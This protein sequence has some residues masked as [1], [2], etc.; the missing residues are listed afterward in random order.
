MQGSGL[1][2][3]G[4]DYGTTVNETSGCVTERL[5]A[6]REGLPSMSYLIKTIW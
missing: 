6:Y 2:S 3:S 5:L 4:S 1:Y